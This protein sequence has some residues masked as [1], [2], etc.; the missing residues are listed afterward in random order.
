[1]D[2]MKAP[3]L[4]VRHLELEDI[5]TIASV[6][7]KLQIPYRYLDVYRGEP[8]PSDVAGLSGLIVM[9]GP[10]GV[11]EAD[12]YPF[13]TAEMNLIRDAME[14]SFPVLGICLGSQLIAGALGARVYP[15]PH[16]EIGWHPV[17]VVKR[18]DPL[19]SGLPSTFPALHWHGDTFDLPARAERLFRSRFYENQGFRFGRNVY[20]LQFHFE[21]D[22]AM[23]DDWL[24][25]KG[26]QREIAAVPGLSAATIRADTQRNADGL[27][28]LSQQVF[29]RFFE[30]VDRG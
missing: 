26:C 7:A 25:D 29:T 24:A 6:L 16:K 30:A 20:A 9:G 12:L 13:L 5:G 18:D 22:A 27:E 15:G 19:A 3:W 14:H 4:V 23:I 11:Y 2:S 8:V 10:M 17:E 28:R 1:M 21:I